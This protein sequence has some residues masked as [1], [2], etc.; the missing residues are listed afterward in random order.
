[1]S[2]EPAAT[3]PVSARALAYAGR[4]TSITTQ[5]ALAR[6]LGKRLGDRPYR[7][8]DQMA[9]RVDT[10]DPFQVAML[11]GLFSRHAAWA[12]RK[13]TRPGS[14]FVD[15][16][17]HIGYFTML[18]AQL[19]GSRGQVHAF[20][21][22]PRLR[23]RVEEHA[24]ANALDWVTVNRMALLDHAGEVSLSLPDQL[25]WASVSL[26]G[27]D[28]PVTATTLDA[29][30]HEHGIDPAAISFVKVDAEGVED[31]VLRG[32]RAT[33]AAARSVALLVEHPPG[34]AENPD[35]IPSFMAG[36]GF[37]PYVPVRHRLGFRLEPGAVPSVGFDVLFLPG[38]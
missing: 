6:R 21:P 17:A 27:G 36:L 16:G 31:A 26:T 2:A 35:A 38:E 12:M 32:G 22:D 8:A 25:G 19:V 15:V 20:E 29:Y 24:R 7:S 9:M 28:V 3:V 33:L 18:G 13:Y 14:V 4:L 30:V 5:L 37:A 34:R 1:M 23:P 10:A 11:T